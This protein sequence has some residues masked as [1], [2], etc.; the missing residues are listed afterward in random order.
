[1]GSRRWAGTALLLTALAIPTAAAA[2]EDDDDVRISI[3][4]VPQVG[5]TL[6]AQVTFD[7]DDSVASAYEWRR[8]TTTA[9]KSCAAI[10]GASGTRYTLTPDDV[11]Q[12]IRVRLTFREDDDDEKAK[13][14][15]S[16]PTTPVVAASAPPPPPVSPPPAST[17]PPPAWTLPPPPAIVTP[18]FTPP[19]GPLATVRTAP[20]LM[21]PA[22][23]VRIAGA[24]TPRGARVTLL[25]VRAPRGAKI[26]LRCTGGCPRRAL[27]VATAL[28]RLRAFERDLNAGTRL[29]I[30]VTRP[31]YVGKHTLI[32]IR[33]G[34]PPSRIDRCLYPGSN[35]PRRCAA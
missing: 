20:R 34:K 6:E 22:P 12:R 21:R 2:Q 11:D 31:G 18:A 19:S 17:L 3:A 13:V 35:T 8:C 23:I 28:T 7:D 10:A 1:V 15:D 9:K 27:A 16:A 25:S 33:R 32:R 5:A 4:G 29:V 14:V 30:R 24:L 26:T